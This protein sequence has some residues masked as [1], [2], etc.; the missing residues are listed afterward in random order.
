M[1]IVSNNL[2]IQKGLHVCLNQTEVR[3]RT[4]HFIFL[5]DLIAYLYINI[6][7]VESTSY[8]ELEGEFLDEHEQ[9]TCVRNVNGILMQIY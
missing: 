9:N 7:L 1:S 3:S 8:N 2:L 6:V 4:F 5:I